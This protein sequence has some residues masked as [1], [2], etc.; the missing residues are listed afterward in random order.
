MQ[1]Q[2]GPTAAYVVVQ[3]P[4]GIPVAVPAQA[5]GPM[6]EPGGTPVYNQTGAAVPPHYNVSIL[7]GMHC[8]NVLIV[9]LSK[10]FVSKSDLFQ[11]YF[12]DFH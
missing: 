12:T 9:D 8:L 7:K 4:D 11:S 2:G 1:T 3:G 5:G 10:V 6:I